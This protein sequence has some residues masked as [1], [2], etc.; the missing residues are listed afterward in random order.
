M[1]KSKYVI[2]WVEKYRPKSWKDIV[3]EHSTMERLK[4]IDESKNMP[5]LLIAGPPGTGK[6]TTAYCCGKAVLGPYSDVGTL[7]L[8]GSD[9][10]GTKVVKQVISHFCKK[11]TNIDKVK[12]A[13][14][15]IIL[16]DEVDNMTQKAQQMISNLMREYHNTTRFIFLCNDSSK[17]IEA[18]Q[19]N[20]II[21]RYKHLSSDSMKKRLKF[22]CDREKLKYNEDGLSALVMT[23]EG[24]MRKAINNLQLI[25]SGFKRV[26]KES[27]YK[28]CDAPNIIYIKYIIEICAD[29]ELTKAL[30]SIKELY[31]KGYS[32]LDISLG[33]FKCIKLGE[34]DIPLKLQYEYGDIISKTCMVVSEGITTELQIVSCICQMCKN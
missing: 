31:H 22:I 9:E 27:V 24:D 34:L 17:I 30:E 11:R 8:N 23:T 4:R 16:I 12:W 21:L 15:K 6:T 26:T 28:L 3:L 5:N 33:L 13:D 29:G 18:I 7:K 20:C 2:Q 1:N 19:S 32:T 14:H 10:R 25:N